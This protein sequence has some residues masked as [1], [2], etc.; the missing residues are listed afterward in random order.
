M[1]HFFSFISAVVMMA[2]MI[3]SC[4]TAAN[5]LDLQDVP[6]TIADYYFVKNDVKTLP[7]G[8]ITSQEEFYRYFG[9]AAV[10]GG[11]PTKINF[12]KQFVIAVCTPETDCNTTI[13]PLTLKKDGK[14]LIFTYN[15]NN[16]AKMGY[17]I[18]PM[19]LIVVDKKY[20]APLKMQQQ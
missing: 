8:I 5:S 15:V 9:E 7:Q 4:K 18:Q 12:K 3:T 13:S 6:F 10:M 16:G 1:K 17:L 14:S 20:E 2:I 19:L 11:L